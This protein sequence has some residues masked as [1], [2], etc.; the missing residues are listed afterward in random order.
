MR[1]LSSGSVTSAQSSVLVLD[2]D[3]DLSFLEPDGECLDDREDI[4][5]GSFSVSEPDWGALLALRLPP[6][7]AART[8]RGCDLDCRGV[9]R[10][11]MPSSASAQYPRVSPVGFSV[12]YWTSGGWDEDICL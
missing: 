2:F 6:V 12:V 9:G 1:R 5:G 3:E 10:S 4:L 11:L 8:G 7:F